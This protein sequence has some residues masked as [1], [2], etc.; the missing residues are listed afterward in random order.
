[1]SMSEYEIAKDLILLNQ[2]LDMVINKLN[3]LTESNNQIVTVLETII[4]S[5][6]NKENS[7]NTR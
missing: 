5:G 3:E 2:K 4:S 1:M 7:N 6:S